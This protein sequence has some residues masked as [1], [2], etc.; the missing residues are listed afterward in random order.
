MHLGVG[1]GEGRM[2]DAVSDA[3]GKQ[4]RDGKRRG[5]RREMRHKQ[6]GLS[7]PCKGTSSLAHEA[8]RRVAT[9]P[10]RRAT[11]RRSPPSLTNTSRTAS[12]SRASLI[13]TCA[14]ADVKSWLLASI[15]ACDVTHFHL[16]PPAT[17]RKRKRMLRQHWLER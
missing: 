11:T 14:S 9:P 10:R 1:L 6:P 15:R 8:D 4:T 3:D 16:P 12:P 5:N 17:R 2:G 7:S 13:G